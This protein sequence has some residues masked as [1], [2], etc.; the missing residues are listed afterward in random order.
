M[1]KKQATVVVDTSIVLKWLIYERDSQLAERLL[2]EWSKQNTVLLAPELLIYE[3]TNALY[4]KA[5]N[6]LLSTEKATNALKELIRTGIIFEPVEGYQ[7]SLK[8]YTYAKRYNLSATYDAH[9]LA[10]ANIEKC[11]LWTADK[12]L[13]DA[14]KGQ[15]PWVHLLEQYRPNSK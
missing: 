10:L 1:N 3:I 6:R 5:R 15:L 7:L 8:A 14:V 13:Y 11:D 2:T 12:R 4:K 9:Y